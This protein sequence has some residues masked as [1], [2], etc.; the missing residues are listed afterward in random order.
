M[1]LDPSPQAAEFPPMPESMAPNPTAL[2]KVWN[3]IYSSFVSAVVPVPPPN[4]AL[5]NDPTALP[6]C[7]LL[8][9][10]PKSVAFPV[11]AIVI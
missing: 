3:E 1:P 2:P 7:P 8:S 4:T 11:V 9:E 5:S 10:S 6:S